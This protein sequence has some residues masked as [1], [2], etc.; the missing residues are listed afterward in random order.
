MV[1]FFAGSDARTRF[2]GLQAV[3]LGVV[4]PV[5]LYACSALSAVLTQVGF[6]VGAV[7]W[8]LFII[9]TA[10]GKDPKLPIVGG[11]CARLVELEQS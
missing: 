6:L 9:S 7:V 3:V 5:V 4:W 1:A 11:L 8:L 2:H 10:A